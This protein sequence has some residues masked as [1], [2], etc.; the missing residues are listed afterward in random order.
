MWLHSNHQI[1]LQL[2]IHISKDARS[3]M[4]AIITAKKKRV[5]GVSAPT[6]N[7][8]F[9]HSQQAKDKFCFHHPPPAVKTMTLLAKVHL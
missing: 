7:S 1:F 5:N 8:L 2:L 6:N 9:S 4:R 3:A